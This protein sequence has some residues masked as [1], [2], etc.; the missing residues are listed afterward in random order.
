MTKLGL[1]S[2]GVC[3]TND[4]EFNVLANMMTDKGITGQEITEYF[5]R[6]HSTNCNQSIYLKESFLCL[7][8]MH[9]RTDVFEHNQ[10][11]QQ[12]PEGR[13]QH[14]PLLV[15]VYQRNIPLIRLLI[16][17]DYDPCNSKFL[18]MRLGNKKHESALDYVLLKDDVTVLRM[19]P[20]VSS[21]HTLN[22]I[23][24]IRPHHA[25]KC[26]LHILEKDRQSGRLDERAGGIGCRHAV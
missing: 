6:I 9:D 18:G 3:D 23:K 12:T 13:L 16:E 4:E 10:P 15:A 20:T 17:A 26:F 24:Q 5:N 1:I 21:S 8:A 11:L 2:H 22:I 25:P 7:A 14:D 19:F